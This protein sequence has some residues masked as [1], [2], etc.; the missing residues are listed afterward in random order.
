MEENETPHVIYIEGLKGIGI[1][2]IAQPK[3]M[4]AFEEW[5]REHETYA[6]R[7]AFSILMHKQDAQDAVCEAFFKIFKKNTV[8]EL[9]NP[10]AYLLTTV[11]HCCCDILRKRKRLLLTQ[12]IGN[13]EEAFSPDTI[14]QALEIESML[15]SL[16]HDMRT[17]IVLRYYYDWSY[18]QIAELLKIP[19]GTVSSRINRAKR[20]LRTEFGQ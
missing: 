19:G 3:N 5:I 15:E 1:L 6:Y 14:G 4:D 8:L 20:R 2:V 13:I 11:H 7:F 12:D 10:K 16:P 18:E 17:A 9:E